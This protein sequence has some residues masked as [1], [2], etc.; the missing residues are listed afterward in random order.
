VRSRARKQVVE[1]APAKPAGARS[2]QRRPAA[3]EESLQ[4]EVRVDETAAP[5]NPIPALVRL[6]S[7]IVEREA[8]ERAEEGR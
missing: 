7:S 6:L 2:A 8:R 3:V 4:L 1:T 5:G